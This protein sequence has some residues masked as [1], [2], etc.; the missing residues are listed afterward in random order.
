M[1]LLS[2][3]KHDYPIKFTHIFKIL[4]LKYPIFN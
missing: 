4:A 3:Q 2:E 1:R